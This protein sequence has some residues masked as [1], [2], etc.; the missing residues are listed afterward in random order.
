[1][2][3]QELAGLAE[4]AFERLGAKA[5]EGL[6]GEPASA[7][8]FGWPSDEGRPPE[9]N[10][11]IKWL[12]ERMGIAPGAGYRPPRRK[13]GGVD[14]VAWRPFPDRRSGFPVFLVQCTLQERI[15]DKALDIDTR[16]WSSWLTLDSE[17]STVLAV[18]G[19]IS[20]PEVWNEIALRCL[21]LDR[22]RLCG[23]LAT[24]EVDSV[25]GCSEVVSRS[26]EAL[27]EEL[28]GA[29]S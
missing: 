9:F 1:L 24:V 11:A 18:P 12:A 21:V 13:D 14:V 6:L 28:E 3:G 20:S 2:V 22:I 25:A 7:V 19:T 4:I 8:R 26:I 29:Q 15:Q 27:A 16:I 5:M 10:L 17:P 23:L